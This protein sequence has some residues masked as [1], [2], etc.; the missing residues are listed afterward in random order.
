MPAPLQLKLTNTGQ[1][2]PGVPYLHGFGGLLH[3][4]IFGQNISGA[5]SGSADDAEWASLSQ[6]T[7]LTIAGYGS[8]YDRELPSGLLLCLRSYTSLICLDTP[9]VIVDCDMLSLLPSLTEVHLYRLVL[10]ARGSN[11]QFTKLVRLAVH[12]GFMTLTTDAGIPVPQQAVAH[13]FPSVEHLTTTCSNLDEDDTSAL[14]AWPLGPTGAMPLLC[15]LDICGPWWLPVEAAHAWVALQSLHLRQF[16]AG[17]MSECVYGS[18]L[19]TMQVLSRL[20]SLHTLH[21][22]GDCSDNDL[23][24]LLESLPRLRDVTLEDCSITAISLAKLAHAPCVRHVTLNGCLDVAIEG[25]AALASRTSLESL[26]VR[27]CHGV[28]PAEVQEVMRLL[29]R[30]QLAI[31]YEPG[32][33]HRGRAAGIDLEDALTLHW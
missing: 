18:V 12:G 20:L 19:P 5:L 15:E 17:C 10:P 32:C 2:P 25:I 8:S 21:V 6:L 3:L 27:K 9:W 13:T 26:T 14:N 28:R 30:P 1:Q 7:K 33:A 4:E 24:A 29:G 16:H 22:A 23:C 11:L 31:D